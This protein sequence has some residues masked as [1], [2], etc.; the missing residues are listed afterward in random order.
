M[1]AFAW[2]RVYL[3]WRE[4]RVWLCVFVLHVYQCEVSV[5][6]QTGRG[7]KPNQVKLDEELWT[8]HRYAYCSGDVCDG[9]AAFSFSGVIC[10][11]KLEIMLLHTPLLGFSFD[12]SKN[13]QN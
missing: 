12:I 10:K 13:K 1:C 5:C 2:A 6:M 8:L 4:E 11:E 7:V 9:M 3:H